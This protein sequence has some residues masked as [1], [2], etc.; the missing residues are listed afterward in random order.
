[1]GSVL[2]LGG[3]DPMLVLADA[4]LGHAVAGAMWGGFANA[5][6][7]CLAVERVYVVEPVYE[8]FLAKLVERAGRIRPGAG[9]GADFGPITLP[10]QLEIIQRHLDDAFARGA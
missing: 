5:G 9:P 2:E 7:T 1:K 3:K 4:N 8:R 10:R 6:Q